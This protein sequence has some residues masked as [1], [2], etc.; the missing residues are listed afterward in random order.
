MH[1]DF[2]AK[3]KAA[4]DLIAVPELSMESIR[5][6]SRAA[7]A[8]GRTRALALCAAVCL[9]VF[10]A[11]VGFGAR[12]YEG[13]RVWLTGGKAAIVVNSFVLVREPTAADV[14]K[15]VAQA[16]FPAVF[17]VGVPAGTHVSMFMFAPAEHPNTITIQ[18]RNDVAHF[19]VGISLFDS[20]VVNT[21][22]ALLP[23]GSARPPFRQGYQWQV[24]RETVFVPKEHVSS[25]LADEIKTAMMRASESGS[26]A[27]TDAMLHKVIVVGLASKLA[28]AAERY[29]PPN[30]RSVLLDRKQ[31]QRLPRLA[32]EN[33]SFFDTRTVYLSN[34]PSVHGDPDYLKATLR[35]P[36][37]IAITA[38]G[39]RAIDAV[40]RS[41]GTRNDCGC[42][43]LF[44]QPDNAT[45]WVWKLPLT[46]SAG[47]RK[48]AV[49]AKT[50]AV[51]QAI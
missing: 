38:A 40:L 27:V 22:A 18:Y 8:R 1:S 28:N 6:R 30:S 29:A 39:I 31:V 23:T 45:Y 35:W 13:V 4:R 21:D 33:E 34:I 19:N 7:A 2:A 48:Y 26:L 9:I 24:G 25:V 20:S 17:P 47:V 43:I 46:G 49:D 12:I 10:G 3:G 5:R 14:H 16:T 36:K 44:D 32:R 51:S 11:S 42:E 50:F 37:T 15:A 41:S